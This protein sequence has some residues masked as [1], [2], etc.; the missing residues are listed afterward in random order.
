LDRIELA[1]RVLGI[2][3]RSG[4]LF[5]TLPWRPQVDSKLPETLVV[6]NVSLLVENTQEVL[7]ARLAEGE[8]V[9]RPISLESLFALLVLTQ[10]E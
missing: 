10:R 8:A 2:I 1:E 7:L 5:R 3:F 6:A 4:L 9:Q